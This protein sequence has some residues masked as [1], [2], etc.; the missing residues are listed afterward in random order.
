MENNNKEKISIFEKFKD[1]FDRNKHKEIYEDSTYL[2]DVHIPYIRSLL[3]EYQV[4]L[5]YCCAKYKELTS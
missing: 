5:E 1:K 2:I 4:E 3:Y